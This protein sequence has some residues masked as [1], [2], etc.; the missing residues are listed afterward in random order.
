M[1]IIHVSPMY[2]PTLGGA[3]LHLKELSES[4]AARG[5]EVTVLTAN[6][7]NPWELWHGTFGELPEGEIINGVNV[8]RFHPSG[9]ILG[10]LLRKWLQLR[11]GYRS[12]RML[13]GKD[14]F[15]M[16]LEKPLTVQ[17]VPFLARCQADIVMSMNW[18]WATSYHTH[19]AGKIRRF[20]LVG[21][22][23]FHTEEKWSERHVYPKMLS[24]CDAVVVN[25]TH[26]AEFARKRGAGR[27]EIAGVGIRPELFANRNGRHMRERYKLGS[28]PVVGFVGRQEANK[29]VSKLVEAMRTVWQWN[30]EVRLIL[31]GHQ[32]SKHKDHSIQ[33][34]INDLQDAERQRI[35]RMNDFAEKDKASLY[36]SIDVLAVPSFAE[37]FGIVYLEAWLCQKPV[38][39]ARIGSTDFLSECAT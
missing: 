27:V 35:I 3:E 34:A 33:T 23:L 14:G 15:E 9:K 10:A 38:I 5:H 24:A 39:G 30:P 7:R 1:K 8:L 29:G 19:L 18:R 17:L 11:G 26:E 13:F 37:S 20:P 32:S 36:D 16:L 6:V 12:V 4:L 28:T 25:T 2:F 22:P 31:A 21:V